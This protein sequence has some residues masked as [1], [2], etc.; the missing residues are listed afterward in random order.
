MRKVEVRV[1][2]PWSYS[3]HGF[4]ANTALKGK[5]LEVPEDLATD[6]VIS[7]HVEIVETKMRRVAPENKG[8][9]K[10]KPKIKE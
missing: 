6:G 3:L 5:V 9:G 8:R 2:K 4:D 7:G 1:L 10:P